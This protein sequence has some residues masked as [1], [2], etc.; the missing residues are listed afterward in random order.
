MLLS[1]LCGTLGAK[2]SGLFIGGMLGA[3][4]NV[5][6]I[7][8][9]YYGGFY[10][11]GFQAP[12]GAA[13]DI[14][15]KTSY[16]FLYGLRVG[17]NA[18]FSQ[19]QGLRFYATLHSGSY[20]AIDYKAQNT[21]VVANIDYMLFFS[22]KPN[23]WGV[24]VGGGYGFSFGDFASLIKKFDKH[25]TQPYFVNFGVIKQLSQK[26]SLELGVKLS[27]IDYAK[28]LISSTNATRPTEPWGTYANLDVTHSI[29]IPAI[30]YFAFDYQF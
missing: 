17:Y 4:V 7:E 18:M 28:V 2:E 10:G 14:D 23:A 15:D 22:N 13:K 5:Y 8:N 11:I 29:K 20:T 26:A 9:H 24:F 6:T 25:T 30:L 12:E 16:D 1:L 3:Y 21:Q 27:P 19:R